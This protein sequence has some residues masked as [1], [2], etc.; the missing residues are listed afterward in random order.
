M[1]TETDDPTELANV[2]TR[3]VGGSREAFAQLVR[4]HHECVRAYLRRFVRSVDD[5]DDL[6]QD[7]FLTAFRGLNEFDFSAPFG[8]WLMGIARNR[9]L[10]HLRSELRRRKRE[11]NGLLVAM[12]E[13]RLRQIEL[14]DAE[15]SEQ[16]LIA[17]RDC[18][19]QLPRNS[20]EFVDQFYFSHRSAVE[21]AREREMKETAVRMTLMRIRRAL[22]DC[23]KQR[24]SQRESIR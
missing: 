20:R 21:I 11:A 24:N 12:A 7:V 22:A 10:H 1:T 4:D 19:D 9:A 18:L 14:F 5:A 15:E 6:A 2:I 16:E 3:A 13:A 8:A 23:I 17:L